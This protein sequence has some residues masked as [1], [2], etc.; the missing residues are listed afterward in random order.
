[1][2]QPIPAVYGNRLVFFA[3]VYYGFYATGSLPYGN[4]AESPKM[5]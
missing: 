3:T 4:S 2:R 5:T 1:L